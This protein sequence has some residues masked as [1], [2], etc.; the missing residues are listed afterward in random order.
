MRK[1]PPGAA[2]AASVTVSLPGRLLPSAPA[3]G[4][5]LSMNLGYVNAA[6]DT[7]FKGGPVTVNAVPA[8]PGAPA[9]PPVQI[10]VSYTGP[11]ASAAGG[12]GP[13]RPPPA[14]ARVVA[15]PRTLTVFEGDGFTFT[16]VAL[17]AS[18]TTLPGTPIVW[19][20]L[21]PAIAAIT[22]PGSGNGTAQG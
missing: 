11:G 7:V 18:G 13:P 12:G 6:G 2:G 15:S 9:P 14:A 8:A 10:P 3:S 4:E 17:D 21:E 20:S 1:G 16:A 22:T 5:P 19:A